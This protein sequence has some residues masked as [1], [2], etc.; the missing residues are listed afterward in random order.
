MSSGVLTMAWGA[1]RYIR[2][3]KGMARSI[4]LLGPETKIAIVSDR[5]AHTLE[6]WFDVV[7]PV[8]PEYGLGLVQKLHLDE[9][10]PFDE[11]LF[12]DSDFLIYK[13]LKQ[14]WERLAVP[15]GFGIL[16]HYMES[17]EAHYAVEDLSKFMSTLGLARMIMT[18]TGM[19]YF[20]AAGI[21]SEVFTRARRLSADAA[22]LGV[23]EH[24]AGGHNDEP[25]LAAA[26][27]QLGIEPLPW[28]PLVFSIG[29]LPMD[30]LR[31]LNVCRHDSRHVYLGKVVE[32]PAIHFNV[33]S[34]KSR[35]YDRELRRLEFGPWLGK[36][37]LPSVVTKLVWL[38]R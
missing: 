32:P 11:T 5:P 29:A 25:L 15:S 1:D 16:G 18:N 4:R 7:I 2:M 22:A 31:G 20:N 10:S 38:R 12:I 9:Y 30:G 13:D 36:T 34:Q 19:L 3:A 28:D 21:A 14:V 6:K 23:R 24:P 8:R 26:A 27:G 37:I 17:G 35:V 33:T